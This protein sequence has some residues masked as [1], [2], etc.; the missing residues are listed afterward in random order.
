MKPCPRCGAEVEYHC[1]D[2]SEEAI[3]AEV[4][5]DEWVECTKCDYSTSLEFHEESDSTNSG[6]SR[7]Q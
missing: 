5:P 1:E 4:S 7:D 6:G 3:A 2:L